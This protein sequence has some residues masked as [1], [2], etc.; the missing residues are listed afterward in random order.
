M[1]WRGL[2]SGARPCLMIVRS[3]TVKQDR[4]NAPGSLL[5]SEL[6]MELATIFIIQPGELLSHLS[7]G[8]C[9]RITG[10]KKLLQDSF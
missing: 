5:C 8:S 4:T 7:S 9:L 1:V 2:S 3:E 6:Q 10:S